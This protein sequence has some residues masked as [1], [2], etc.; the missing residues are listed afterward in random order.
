MGKPCK[1]TFE[2]KTFFK[3]D[4]IKRVLDTL[5]LDDNVVENSKYLKS[6]G[7]D[8]AFNE[9]DPMLI[10]E[11]KQE[12]KVEEVT[13]KI[14]EPKESK[15]KATTTKA[16]SEQT[17]SEQLEKLREKARS[18][19]ASRPIASAAGAVVKAVKNA[20]NWQKTKEGVKETK[21]SAR[22]PLLTQAAKD[23]SQGKITNEEYRAIE[24]KSSPIL[25]IENFIEPATESQVANSVDKSKVQN[26][27][28]PVAPNTRVG[29]RIDIPAFRNN[30]V[31]VISVHDGATKTGSIISYKGAARITDVTFGTQSPASSLKIATGQESKNAQVGRI[32]GNWNNFDG[33]TAEEQNQSAKELVEQIQNDP[34]WVQVG[35]NPFRH[36]YFYDRSNDLGRPV[37]SAKEVVQIGG[38]VYAKDVVYGNWNDEAYKVKGMLDKAGKPVFFSKKPKANVIATELEIDQEIVDAM[39]EMELVNEGADLSPATTKQKT[40]VKE[41]NERLDT[42]LKA[43]KWD[44]FEGMPFGFTISDQLRSGDTTNPSTDDIVDDLKGGLGFNGTDG[45]QDKAWAN[46]TEEEAQA[47][48][49]KAQKVYNNNK[50]LFE[51]LWADGKL[52]QGVVPFAV[53][54]M[55]ETS[56]LS[57]E[58]VFRVGAQNISTLPKE[59]RKAALVVMKQELARKIANL[60]SDLKRGTK[61]IEDKKNKTII[62]T[63]EPYSENTKKI[64]N[65]EINQYQKILDT[66]KK[67]KIKDIVDL[68]NKDKKFSLPERVLIGKEIF[69]GKPTPIEGKKVDPTKSRPG[70]AVSIALAKDSDKS[71]INIGNITDVLTEPSMK[72][73]PNV[74]I[75]AVVGV[76]VAENNDGKWTEAGGPVETNHPNYPY[77][78]QG[79]SIGVLSQPI[80]VKDAFGEAYGSAMSQITENEASNKTLPLNKAVSQGIP[81]SS[82][83]P[84]RTFISAIAKTKLDAV[85]KL[86]GF[87]RQAF[88]GTTFF[89]SQDAWDAAMQDPAVSK[90]LKDG[91]VVYAFTK[92]GNVFINPNL[93]TTKAS[94][95]EVGHIWMDFM[96]DS[97]PE[98]F[99]KGLSLVEGTQELKDAIAQ[100]GD[101][102]LA[103]EEALMEIMSSKGDTIVNSAQKAKVK[104]WLLSVWKY[105]SEQFESL[106]GLTP[107]QVE[108]LTLDKFVEGMLADVLSGKEIT[109]KKTKGAT[110]FS[111]ESGNDSD[112]TNFVKESL[113]EGYSKEAISEML[114]EEFGK[115]KAEANQLIE[116]N[117]PKASEPNIFDD[118]DASN[119]RGGLRSQQEAKKAF[120]EKHGENAAIAKAISTNFEAISKELE[121]KG[122]FKKINCK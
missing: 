29:L 71:L 114:Q 119:K 90:K 10:R 42:P 32:F 14:E 50:P 107:Q 38:L 28:K 63:K 61:I 26:A 100:Y 112:A 76:K 74:H 120:S 99:K 86:S 116:Q 11:K 23:L 91:D 111:K 62:D 6:I 54:K 17:K 93:K 58:A 18:I 104:E 24:S 44:A 83:M 70:T 30:N 101:N 87:L 1:V 49:D 110:K 27:N 92:N 118:F 60:K 115:T 108:N 67:D 7:Y 73:V 52:P 64:K 77:G 45:N 9:G 31:W 57:N 79:Q 68:L 34:S 48:H 105:V 22:N 121:A 78:V 66:I 81:V 33:K 96:K 3:P 2:G 106:R 51:K 4:F 39:N 97:N 36:S 12:A 95:H 25:P 15:P 13:S 46:T 56:I 89:T 88:P 53:V 37:L 69:Y 5:H 98:L 85:D 35:M 55:A 47:M 84:N 82:G 40:D 113:D 16:P 72:D 41:L 103:R 59:N 117:S 102:E 80:H 20:I 8:N 65:K 21:I 94:L 109:S 19:K 122:I 75:I 43:V